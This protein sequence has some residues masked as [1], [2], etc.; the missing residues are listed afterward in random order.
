M[1]YNER[2]T[3]DAIVRQRDKYEEAVARVAA[4]EQEVTNSRQRVIYLQALLEE[5]RGD[6][7]PAQRSIDDQQ[8]I[9]SLERQLF[10]MKSECS[11]LSAEAQLL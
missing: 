2:Y 4:L 10:S 9:D 1:V 6:R 11:T 8:L 7:P 3:R 5:D